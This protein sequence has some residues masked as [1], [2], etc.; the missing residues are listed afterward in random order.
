[1]TKT[2]RIALPLVVALVAAAPAFAAVTYQSGK[3]VGHT[4]QRNHEGK[5]R[6]FQFRADYEGSEVRS[7]KFVE[8]THCSDG[9][10]SVGTQRGLRGAVDENGDFTIKAVS[11]THATHITVK[12]HIEGHKAHGTLN[13]RSRFNKDNQPDPNGSIKCHSGDVKWWAKL[14][15]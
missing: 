1:M 11:D 10:N 15:S 7:M 12:G 3:Y 5:H 9:F 14:A 2:P 6:K 13:A 8:S 4:A